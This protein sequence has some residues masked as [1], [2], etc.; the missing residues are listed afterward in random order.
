M[1]NY[2]QDFVIKKNVQKKKKHGALWVI[3]IISKYPILA[4]IDYS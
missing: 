4:Y 1:P 3:F 2:Y